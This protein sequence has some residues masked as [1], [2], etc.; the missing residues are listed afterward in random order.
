MLE[1][2][3]THF[4]CLRGPHPSLPVS[5]IFPLSHPK[6]NQQEEALIFSETSRSD[7]ATRKR[8]L[9][10]PSRIRSTA[11]QA[12]EEEEESSYAELSRD[13]EDEGASLY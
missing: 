11:L 7:L 3:F 1:L 2:D 10:P 6:G 12:E 13:S 4:V 8:S 5:F 9:P